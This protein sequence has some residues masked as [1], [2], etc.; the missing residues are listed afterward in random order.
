MSHFDVK[1]LRSHSS[2]GRV[3]MFRIKGVGS[4]TRVEERRGFD[5]VT[6]ICEVS[7]LPKKAENMLLTGILKSLRWYRTGSSSWSYSR[8]H[9]FDIEVTFPLCTTNLNWYLLN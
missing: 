9:L 1:C 6:T 2:P 3:K 5:V 7:N 4:A 8:Y